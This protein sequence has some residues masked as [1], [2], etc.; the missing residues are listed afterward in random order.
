MNRGR[1]EGRAVTSCV[2]TLGGPKVLMGS[3][4]P[5]PLDAPVPTALI[6][7]PCDAGRRRGEGGSERR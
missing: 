2:R 1:I 4:Q 3:L 7:D 5:P 6:A